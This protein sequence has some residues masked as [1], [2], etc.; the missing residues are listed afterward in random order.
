M[1]DNYLERRMED[2]RSGKLSA[3]SPHHT[4]G[5][6]HITD[7]SALSGL[8]VIITDG[9]SSPT[10]SDI[11]RN[12]L[13]EGCKVAFM[14]TDSKEGSKLA[15]AF[16]AQ[17]HP[18]MDTA[19]ADALSTAVSHVTKR[20]GGVDVIIDLSSHHFAEDTLNGIAPDS[21]K[22]ALTA[23]LTDSAPGVLGSILGSR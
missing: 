12:L 8:R 10:A 19:S 7:T 23:P 21:M 11:V 18:V 20:W 17:F 22:I 1:A 5:K 15:Q 16:G 2:Y 13:Q 6:S 9:L 14:G 3:R 4:A